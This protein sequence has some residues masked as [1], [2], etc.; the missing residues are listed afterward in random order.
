MLKLPV[1]YQVANDRLSAIIEQRI[2]QALPLPLAVEAD[3]REISISDHPDFGRARSSWKGNEARHH[4][5]D[6]LKGIR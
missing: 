1:N 6:F 5:P 4:R 2:F 3:Q